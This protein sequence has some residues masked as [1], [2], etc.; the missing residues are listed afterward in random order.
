M[1]QPHDRADNK[2]IATRFMILI[3]GLMAPALYVKRA[4]LGQSEKLDLPVIG[5]Q[6]IDCLIKAKFRG[7][8][9]Q[10]EKTLLLFPEKVKELADKARIFLWGEP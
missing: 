2:S 9:F 4:K 3:K 10:A 8:A 1:I 5:P 7:L 6:T